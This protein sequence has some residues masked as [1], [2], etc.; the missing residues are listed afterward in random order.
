LNKFS[1]HEI[2]SISFSDEK[3]FTVALTRT[4][5]RRQPCA[6]AQRTTARCGGGKSRY[7]NSNT[8]D[9]LSCSSW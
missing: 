1:E 9:L 5:R 6:V 8:I 2:T 7:T 4:H 3:L